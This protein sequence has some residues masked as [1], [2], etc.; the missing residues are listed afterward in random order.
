VSVLLGDLPL[1]IA[2]AVDAPTP[3]TRLREHARATRAATLSTDPLL[4]A[5]GQ[6]SATAIARAYASCARVESTELPA[7]W[8][9]P[10]RELVATGLL[11]DGESGCPR[12]AELLSVNHPD[13][14]F[15]QEG[16][17]ALAEAAAAPI[18]AL[19]R[20][21]PLERPRGLVPPTRRRA[22][23]IVVV[24][25]AALVA[26]VAASLALSRPSRSR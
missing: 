24:A 12:I 23:P 5:I 9:A 8:P 14:R 16:N 20:I 26:L 10:P 15:G 11:D 4:A 7:R 6:R 3:L 1:A 2:T 17:A 25:L 13:V 21:G 22:R 19:P 18:S